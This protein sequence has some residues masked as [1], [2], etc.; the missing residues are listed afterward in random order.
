MYNYSRKALLWACHN[1]RYFSRMV[2]NNREGE[3]KQLRIMEKLINNVFAANVASGTSGTAPVTYTQVTQHGSE[4]KKGL[5]SSIRPW[6]PGLEV[7]EGS[8]HL[9]RGI[10]GLLSCGHKQQGHVDVNVWPGAEP[11]LGQLGH[12]ARE[13][14]PPRPNN[15]AANQTQ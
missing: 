3:K 6:Q 8:H 10:S 5:A 11:P 9:G 12:N 7:A 1:V 2:E 13:E 14:G 4:A 15:P